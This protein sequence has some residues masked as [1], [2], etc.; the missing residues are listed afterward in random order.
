MLVPRPI[1]SRTTSERRVAR[2]RTFAVSFISTMK[3]L[4][5][6]A[7]LSLAPTRVST[8]STTPMRARRAGTNEPICARITTSATCRMSVDLPAMFGPVTSQR[9]AARRPCVRRRVERDVVRHEAPRG[10]ELL[11]DGVARVLEHELERV[12][13]L[14][15]RRSRR[16][17]RPRRARSPRP[18]RRGARRRARRRS[19]CAARARA[20]ARAKSSASRVGAALLGVGELV[21][22][23]RRARR[24]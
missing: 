13:D 5:P 17:A 23:R 3:V 16:G 15:P 6:R 20:R 11:D 22:E 10:G 14:G 1:S 7:R 2:R 18:T 9:R 4:S 8:R 19:T 24:T 21:G 12:V